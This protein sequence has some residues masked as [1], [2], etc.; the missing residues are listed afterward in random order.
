MRHV[1]RT[2]RTWSADR[3]ER[4]WK[5]GRLGVH[6]AQVESHGSSSM[7]SSGAGTANPGWKGV[8]DRIKVGRGQPVLAQAPL[9]G[10]LLQFHAA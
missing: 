3:A 2:N 4:W 8:R 9:N 5:T 10:V 7:P 6:Q 1:M